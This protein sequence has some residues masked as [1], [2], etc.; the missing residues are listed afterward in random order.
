VNG[1]LF[2][3]PANW[4]DTYTGGQLLATGRYRD[5]GWSG[6]GPSLIAYR[7]W[8]DENGTPAADGTHLDGTVLLLYQ[9]SENTAAIEHA[10][11]GYQHA[12]EWEGGAWVTTP[13]G[14]TAVLFAGTKSIGEKYWYGWVNPDGPQYAC[15][16]TEMLGQFTLCYNADGSA[17]PQ[18]DLGGC[19]P[20]N[21]YRG[22]WSDQFEAQI[23][24]YNP[25]DL[26][27]VASG[28]IESWEPQPYAVL[29]L[30]EALFHN[31]S[32][33]ETD[34]IGSGDQRRFRIGDVAYDPANGLL[35]VLELFADD[36]KPVVH[37][38][39]IH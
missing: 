24:L 18:A 14:K 6:M 19:S 4:A 31:P 28:E 32:G 5:G 13:S 30:E 17:C 9:S 2:T 38:W 35:Y 1:Y 12:D 39:R 20:H 23:L 16:E 15:V 21:D 34:M 36:A 8:V 27:R 22:W 25:A 29:S 10:L 11:T 3:I 33:V 7:P 26:A 37:V